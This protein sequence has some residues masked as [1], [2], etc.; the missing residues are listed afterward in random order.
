MTLE[1][2]AF[3]TM[4]D[5]E[6]AD[7]Q[8][9]HRDELDEALHTTTYET[10]EAQPAKDVATVTSFRMPPGEL[11]QIRIAAKAEGVTMSEWI[12]GACKAALGRGGRRPHLK[13][14]GRYSRRQGRRPVTPGRGAAS[15]VQRLGDPGPSERVVK[16]A[17][18]PAGRS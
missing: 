4:S 9:A 11:E 13:S 14:Y 8:H 7:W 6:I 3:S 16:R 1:H 10:V 15:A 12:R 5:A 2:P 17:R 18:M